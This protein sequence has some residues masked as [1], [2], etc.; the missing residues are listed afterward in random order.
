MLCVQ[1]EGELPALQQQVRSLA[2]LVAQGQ[3]APSE[4]AM[5]R[6]VRS[7]VNR[8][9]LPEVLE[10]QVRACIPNGDCN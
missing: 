6:L 5:Q 1:L 2:A 7:A 4:H 9:L 8:T 10:R 3:Q